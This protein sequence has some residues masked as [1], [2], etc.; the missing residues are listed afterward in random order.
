MLLMSNRHLKFN[1]S[2]TG[3]LIKYPNVSFFDLSICPY[4]SPVSQMEIGAVLG[5]FLSVIPNISPSLDP[6]AAPSW[7][8]QH[9]TSSQSSSA[10]TLVQA[11]ITYHL[12]W[13]PVSTPFSCLLSLTMSN[14]LPS[15]T[16]HLWPPF[17]WVTLLFLSCSLY[18]CTFLR[19]NALLLDTH[20]L[21]PSDHYSNITFTVR[22]GFK[23]SKV[24]FAILPTTM[25]LPLPPHPTYDSIC[26]FS[27]YHHLTFIICYFSWFYFGYFMFLTSS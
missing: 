7:Y 3:P 19:W 8:I 16:F 10:T 15:S 12:Y 14:Y 11:T 25:L 5:S 21:P 17:L 23:N 20:S 1:L 9:L 6:R 18:I 13:N 26:F 22:Q 2:K 27:P 24:A 4:H